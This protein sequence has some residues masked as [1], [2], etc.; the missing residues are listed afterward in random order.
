MYVLGQIGAIVCHERGPRMDTSILN[1]MASR[2]AEGFWLALTTINASSGVAQGYGRALLHEKRREIARLSRTL[3]HPL[4]D[5][6]SSQAQMP[7]WAGYC[8][9]WDSMGKLHL[10]KEGDAPSRFAD[11]DQPRL[12][13]A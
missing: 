6:A 3:A 9:Y 11:G 10:D 2:P 12:I 1:T 8:H 4:P 5:A 13:N 7:F